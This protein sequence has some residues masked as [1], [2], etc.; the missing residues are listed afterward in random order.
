MYV[1]L[2][3]KPKSGKIILEKLGPDDLSFIGVIQTVIDV[4]TDK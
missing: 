2:N 3:L 1:H 4:H